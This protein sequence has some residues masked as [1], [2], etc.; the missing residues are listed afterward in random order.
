[1]PGK[2][3]LILNLLPL[4]RNIIIHIHVVQW[5][6]CETGI[7]LDPQVMGSNPGLGKSSAE[8]SQH[9]IH[10]SMLDLGYKAY[11]SLPNVTLDTWPHSR[12]CSMVYL[13]CSKYT[14]FFMLGLLF[15]SVL[16]DRCC[17]S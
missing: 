8:S 9:V 11:L 10:R 14:G 13:N 16:A 2:L 6:G 5:L 7:L 3:L 1:M 12:C 17:S 15:F 4:H